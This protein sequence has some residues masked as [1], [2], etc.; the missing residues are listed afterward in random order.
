MLRQDIIRPTV[1]FAVLYSVLVLLF[2]FFVR[3]GPLTFGS[4]G[5]YV[6]G[7]IVGTIAFVVLVRRKGGKA[8]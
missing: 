8:V 3:E 7:G 4:I 5:G 2:I 6:F 1:L